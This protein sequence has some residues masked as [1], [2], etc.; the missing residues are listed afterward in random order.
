MAT[1]ELKR[2]FLILWDPFSS[3][4]HSGQTIIKEME[5]LFMIYSILYQTLLDKI[6]GYLS[7]DDLLS[8]E[9]VSDVRRYAVAEHQYYELVKLGSYQ[10]A[11][12]K[13]VADD[14]TLLAGPRLT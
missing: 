7:L 12:E 10:D 8:L 4:R 1:S 5:R 3:F 9:K 6:C 11:T 13:L 2:L 14:W